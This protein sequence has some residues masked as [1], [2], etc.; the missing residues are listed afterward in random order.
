MY[1]R[2]LD[3]VLISPTPIWQYILG[4]VLDGGLR[5]VCAGLLISLVSFA[6]GVIVPVSPLFLLIMLLNGMIFSA[7]GVFAAMNAKDHAQVARYSTYLILPMTFR[8]NTFLFLDKLP[9]Y[10][11]RPLSDVCH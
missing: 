5:S 7:F 8:R 4:Q 11:R 9:I 3:Q 2:S 10:G 1:D 6:F